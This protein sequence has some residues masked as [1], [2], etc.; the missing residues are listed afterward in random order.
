MSKGVTLGF[1]YKMR[2]V[3]AHF[4]INVVRRVTLLRRM[5]FLLKSDVSWVKNVC[6]VWMRPGVDCSVSL[7]PRKMSEFL[8]EMT[9]NFHQIQLLGFSKPQ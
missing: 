6:R 9:L 1:H 8:K 7:K 5:V 2:S 3:C 4:P